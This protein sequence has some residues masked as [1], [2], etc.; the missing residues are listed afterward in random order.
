MKY[1]QTHHFPQWEKNDRILMADFNAMCANME[2]SL[3]SDRN[4]CKRDNIILDERIA[5]ARKIAEAAQA[6][7][8]EAKELQHYVTGSYTGNGGTQSIPLGFK[9]AF[10]VVSGMLHT[11]ANN[12]TADYDRYFALTAGHVLDKRVKLTSTGFTVYPAP[13]QG[14]NNPNLNQEGRT[15]DYIAFK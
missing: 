10:L 6:A 12:T 9:P 11:L 2:K 7:A 8:G 15:Y 13:Y 5:Q 14:M 4:D 3:V 1:T